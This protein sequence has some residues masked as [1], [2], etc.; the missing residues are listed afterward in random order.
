[1]RRRTML[2]VSA[3]VGCFCGLLWVES[4]ATERRRTRHVP[5]RRVATPDA[6]PGAFGGSG[7][8]AHEPE[9]HERFKLVREAILKSNDVDILGGH[10]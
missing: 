3:A 10:E 5:E 1:M 9:H 8:H 4:I 2:A 7:E 6:Q